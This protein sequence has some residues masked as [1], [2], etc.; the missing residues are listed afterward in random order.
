[1]DIS[2]PIVYRPFT[3]KDFEAVAGLFRDQW[4]CE[5][6]ADAA[7]LA[8]QIDI[9]TYLADT[10]WSL[11]AQHGETGQILGA[12]LLHLGGAPHQRWVERKEELFA[13]ARANKDL[14]NEVM[15]D[16]SVIDEEAALGSEYAASG[17]VG[18]EAE[19]KLLIVSP[20]AQGLGV[21]GRLFGAVREQIAESGRRGFFLLTDDSCDVS[22]YEHK[23]MQCMETRRIEAAEPPCPIVGAEGG[24]DG[25][26]LYVYAQEVR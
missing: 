22:F 14:L 21:G 26:N 11:L 17:H 15:R 10:D 12:A 5:L 6:G 9:C 24:D 2:T 18:C 3:D 16:V 23:K 8:S 20:A 1:M 13:E 7:R 25:F 4:C 19:L